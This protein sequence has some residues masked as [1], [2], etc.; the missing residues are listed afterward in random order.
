MIQASLTLLLASCF[1]STLG[2]LAAGIHLCQTCRL[3][4]E[5][6]DLSLTMINPVQFTSTVKT[7]NHLSHSSIGI[8]T[9]TPFS[10]FGDS[11]HPFGYKMH[12]KGY[13]SLSNIFNDGIYLLAPLRNS[14][15]LPAGCTVNKASLRTHKKDSRTS[16][17]TAT[18][19][20]PLI[21]PCLK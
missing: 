5:H 20:S 18:Y 9:S 12:Q 11:A 3:L 2:G 14:R 17:T 15:A 8:S 21:K 16:S 19:T 7:R 1:A 4:T 6:Y 13:Y 10:S